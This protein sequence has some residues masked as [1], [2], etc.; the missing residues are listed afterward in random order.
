MADDP[1]AH[2]VNVIAWEAIARSGPDWSEIEWENFPQLGEQDWAPV[3]E[4]VNVL[5][6]SMRQLGEQ[7]WTAVV[8]R[9]KV[10]AASMRPAQGQYDAAYDFLS[11]RATHD[12]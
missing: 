5:V 4:R 1:V 3:V 7:D 10:L 8:E 9:V 12:A 6:S 11:E 2:A